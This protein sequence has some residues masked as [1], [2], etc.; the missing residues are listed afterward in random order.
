MFFELYAN[1]NYVKKSN[2]KGG[3]RCLFSACLMPGVRLYCVVMKLCHA[4]KKELQISKKIARQEECPFCRAD[5]Y[6]CLNCKFYDR[7]SSQ[8]CREPVAERV[9]DKHKANY[10]DFFSFREDSAATPENADQSRKEL[11]DL[12]KRP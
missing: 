3:E 11:N 2:G 6:C 5:L 12:F 10:C 1:W 4:C 8:N 9:K 7:T